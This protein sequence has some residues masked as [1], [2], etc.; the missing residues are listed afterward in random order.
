[1]LSLAMGGMMGLFGRTPRLA[2]Q[3]ALQHAADQVGGVVDMSRYGEAADTQIEHGVRYDCAANGCN[4][5]CRRGGTVERWYPTAEQLAGM[6]TLITHDGHVA[7]PVERKVGWMHL[8][9]IRAQG[10]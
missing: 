3:R 1:M 5:P 9:T 2:T 8:G 4:P 6:P 10:R 7:E